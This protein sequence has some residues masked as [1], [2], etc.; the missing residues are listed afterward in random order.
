M[1]TDS[2]SVE[3]TSRSYF[4]FYRARKIVLKGKDVKELEELQEKARSLKL[5]SYLVSDAGHTQVRLLHEFRYAIFEYTCT[6]NALNLQVAAGS[7]TVLGIFG[8]QDIV[9]QVTG[10]LSTL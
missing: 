6:L 5:V 3:Y 2:I 4:Y 9:N 10:H 8:R 7:R 1:L